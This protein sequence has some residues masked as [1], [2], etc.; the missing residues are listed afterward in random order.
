MENIFPALPAGENLM[1]SGL[2]TVE[3]DYLITR[4]SR[5]K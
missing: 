5:I 2:R 4:K 1:I 3:T